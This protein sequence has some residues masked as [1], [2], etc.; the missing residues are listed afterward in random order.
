[1]PGPA[2]RTAY[3]PACARCPG[4]FLRLPKSL[5]EVDYFSAEQTLTHVARNASASRATSLS[6]LP[7]PKPCHTRAPSLN[8]VGSPQR[9][10]RTGAKI[11][12][13]LLSP[14]GFSARHLAVAIREQDPRGRLSRQ[15][16]A[17][18]A[19]TSGSDTGYS[20]IFN[21][22]GVVVRW[23]TSSFAVSPM[24]FCGVC[25]RRGGVW[26]GCSF[27]LVVV[28]GRGGSV[29]VLGPDRRLVGGCAESR[30]G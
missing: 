22:C 26:V 25:A 4:P 19:V 5:F 2:L 23:L 27:C 29:S 20:L 8:P 14:G 10:E 17:K 1:M 12:R 6:G 16:A 21:P 15:R 24:V 9:G 18:Q 13:P 3:A 30:G 11:R 28:R 7:A